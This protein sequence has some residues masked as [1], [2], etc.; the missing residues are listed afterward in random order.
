MSVNVTGLDKPN[1]G[2]VEVTVDDV[3]YVVCNTG[4]GDLD[5]RVLCRQLNYTDGVL[6]R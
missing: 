2:R 5:A 4:W 1:Y 6:F 3:A